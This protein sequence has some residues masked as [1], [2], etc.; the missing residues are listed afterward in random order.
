[1]LRVGISWKLREG[2]ME[3]D[4]RRKTPVKN[5]GPIIL[6]CLTPVIVVYIYYTGRLMPAIYAF[7]ILTDTFFT[8][9][10]CTHV[11]HWGDS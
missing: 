3:T 2:S 8:S 1:M 5:S 9:I 6:Y 7:L 4:L 10:F 11:S